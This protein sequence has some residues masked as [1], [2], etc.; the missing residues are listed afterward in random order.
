M[1]VKFTIAC[2]KCKCKAELRFGAWEAAGQFMCPN[3]RSQ[4]G[5]TMYTALK[6]TAASISVLSSMSQNFS[7]AISCP[8]PKEDSNS[9]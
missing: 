7:V 3:C 5:P 9:D 2:Q 1:D 6:E 4:M 8:L